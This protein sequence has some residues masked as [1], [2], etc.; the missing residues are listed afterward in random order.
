MI[1]V[2][3][4]GFGTFFPDCEAVTFPLN[5]PIRVLE[6]KKRQSS[7]IPMETSLFSPADDKRD[8]DESVPQ[9]GHSA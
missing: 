4:F 6:N 2:E 1:A 7:E 8:R 5:R 9:T 3:H